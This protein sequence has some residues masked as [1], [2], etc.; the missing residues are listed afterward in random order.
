MCISNCALDDLGA[1]TYAE[2]EKLDIR[3]LVAKPALQCTHGILGLDGLGAYLVANLEVERDILRT[4][5][6]QL[7]RRLV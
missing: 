6:Q 3:I 1:S 5:W 7:R 2:S 4:A